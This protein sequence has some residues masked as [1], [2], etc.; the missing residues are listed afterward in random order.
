MTQ[1]NISLA[2]MDVRLGNPRVNWPKMQEMA[3]QAKTQ[4]G[5]LAVFPELW[6]A[7]YALP[8]AKDLASSLSGGLF[9]QVGALSKQ[10]DLFITGSMLEKRGV[11]VANCAPLIS[12]QAGIMGAYRKTHLFPLMREDQWLS[13]GESTLNIQMPWGKT[14]VAICYDLR[15]PELFR[16]YAVEGAQVVLLPCQWPEPR[17]EHYRTLV[18]ARAIENGLYMVA[19]NRVGEDTPEDGPTTRYFGHSMVVDPFGRIVIELGYSEGVHT[20]TLDMAQVEAARQAIPS[21]AGRRPEVY[22]SF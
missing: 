6:D 11:G 21:L 10:L 14:A 5:Q 18:Q 16:R 2:Q 13:A 12:P 19:V 20:V 17:I 1:V 9:A 15:F 7:G 4:G 22:G 8:K 3:Q